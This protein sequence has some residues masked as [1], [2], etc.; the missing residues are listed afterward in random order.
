[1]NSKELRGEEG[2]AAVLITLLLIFAFIALTA[3]AIDGGHLYVV[4]RDLQ[5]MSD[6]ACLAAATQLSLGGDQDA[7]IDKAKEYVTRNGGSADLYTPQE[8][9]GLGLVKGIQVSG[10]DVR[11][12][13]QELVD[14]YFT[15]IFNRSGAL[16]GARSRCNAVA[17]GGLLPIAVRRYDG[18][19]KNPSLMDLLANKNCLPPGCFYHSDHDGVVWQGR[20]GPMTIWLPRAVPGDGELYALQT[21]NIDCDPPPP[22]DVYVGACVLGSGVTTNDGTS[23]Y[24]GFV[25]LDARNVAPG[26]VE[27]YNG[28][29]GQ[30]DTNKDISK[31]WIRQRGY[32]GPMPMVGDQLAMLDG[33]S[34]AFAAQ[35]M[36]QYWHVGEEFWAIVY[37]G[38]IWDIPELKVSIKPEI[39]P[40]SPTV[41][42]TTEIVT[43]TVTL[44]KPKPWDG[45]ANFALQ[46]SFMEVGGEYGV[47]SPTVNFSPNPVILLQG[48]NSKSVSMT[49]SAFIT[50]TNLLSDYLS[51]LTVR[52][53]EITGVG[54]KRWASTNFRYGDIP[55]GKDFTLYADALEYNVPQG[56]SLEIYLTT[57]G[58]GCAQNKVDLNARLD[59]ATPTWG[60]VFTSS[61]SEK[62]NKIL[63]GKDSNPT[64]TLN[65]KDDAPTTC[66]IFC[67]PQTAYPVELTVG[68]ACGQQHSV[69][70]LVNVYPPRP[71]GDPKR[72]VIVE[73]FAPF[74]I[75]YVDPNPNT[76]TIGAYAIGPIVNC[77]NCPGGPT[78]GLNPRLLSWTQ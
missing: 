11:V 38:Y 27:Y 42:N 22:D 12:A 59:V 46:A 18:F 72:F 31:Q 51:A 16:V 26:P 55:G 40:M 50:D 9:G 73:G 44:E 68:P 14:T 36:H 23:D 65:V 71:G 5:N 28:A 54:L 10:A 21:G 30:A 52:A 7:A 47:I 32:A 45:D 61:Q 64:F 78:S 19:G 33:V 6:A 34:N 58:F 69:R 76:N 53:Q 77:F 57:R 37:S 43:Y 60:Q 4:R 25:L 70:I 56:G 3:L 48:E 75:S 2:Q 8:G 41:T 35:E 62:I 49:V 15:M 13:L 1:M 67:T 24:R 17:G 74:R 63:D 29:T 66:D 20:Y 39:Q